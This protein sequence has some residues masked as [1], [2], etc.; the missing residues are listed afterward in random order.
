MEVT[1]DPRL[2]T[3]N[4]VQRRRGRCFRVLHEGESRGTDFQVFSNGNLE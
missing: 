4:Q 3:Q 2:Y 1:N